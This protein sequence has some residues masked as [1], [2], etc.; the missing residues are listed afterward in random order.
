ME[1]M[2]SSF[3]SFS[4]ANKKDRSDIS[5]WIYMEISAGLY[6]A[7][8]RIIPLSNIYPGYTHLGVLGIWYQEV[9][10]VRINIILDQTSPSIGEYLQSETYGDNQLQRIWRV[11]HPYLWYIY[12][13]Y[14]YPWDWYW[15]LG[16]IDTPCGD[17]ELAESCPFY[18]KE[19][20]GS[21]TGSKMAWWGE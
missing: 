12:S 4:R 5:D 14:I 9:Y 10:Q 13:D 19:V 3:V 16:Y 20:L 2:V 11:F 15:W 21:G 1:S 6:R 17:S 8:L 18:S 7:S